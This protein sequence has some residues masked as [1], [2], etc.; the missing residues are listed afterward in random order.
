MSAPACCQGRHLSGLA[1]AIFPGA[2]VPTLFVAFS[3]TFGRLKILVRCPGVPMFVPPVLRS[4]VPVALVSVAGVFMEFVWNV[5]LR[6]QQVLLEFLF[7][8]PAP[9]G[10][11]PQFPG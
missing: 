9:P 4:S 10:G 6:F 3:P 1:P 5:V 2:G 8:V 7:R 11:V